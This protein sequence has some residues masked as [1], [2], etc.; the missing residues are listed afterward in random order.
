V[1]RGL[2]I[3]AGAP[4]EVGAAALDALADALLPRLCARLG[5]AALAAEVVD[6]LTAVPGP[7]RTIMAACRRGEI[8]GAARIGRRWC[9]A[10]GA[11]EVWIRAHGPRLVQPDDGADELEPLR[12]SLA[13]P[14]RRRPA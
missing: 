4:G 8:S 5:S 10:R 6:V 7:R 1:R 12:R 11:I 9:A 2:S 14:A 3:A 13:Q